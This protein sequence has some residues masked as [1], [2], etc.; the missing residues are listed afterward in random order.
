MSKKIIIEIQNLLKLYKM[1]SS[2]KDKKDDIEKYLNNVLNDLQ[3]NFEKFYKMKV[4]YIG[5]IQILEIGN[6]KNNDIN[7][8]ILEIDNNEILDNIEIP[9]I[10]DIS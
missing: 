5:D 3:Q 4:Y 2:V 10:E 7:T 9:R 1:L 6:K 8:E